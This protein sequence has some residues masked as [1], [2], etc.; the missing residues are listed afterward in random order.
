M[1]S[2]LALSTGNAFDVKVQP[3]VEKREKLGIDRWTTHMRYTLTNAL[4]KPVTVTL[5]QGGLWAD[6]TVTEESLKS[7]RLSAEVRSGR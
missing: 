2:T 3:V 4:L 1:G 6:S 7:M 5:W